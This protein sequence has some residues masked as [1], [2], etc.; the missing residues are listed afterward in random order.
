MAAQASAIALWTGVAVLAPALREELD[1]SLTQVG[2]VIAAPW[3][4]PIFTLLP[5]GIAADRAGE[6]IVLAAGLGLCASLTVVIAF[7][8]DFGA[9]V[10]LL[11][12]AG[13]AGA[14]TNAASGR[15]VMSWFGAEERGFALGIRQASTPVGIM[16]ASLALPALDRAGGLEAAFLFLA[17]FAL[18]AAVA[19]LL[20]LRDLPAETGTEEAPRVLRDRRLWLLGASAGLYLVPQVAITGF[21]VLFLHDERELS[22]Q[23][24]AAVLAVI[25][26][27][28]IPLRI[29]I[30][31][32]SDVAGDRIE[33]LRL[34]GLGGA[35]TLA[36]TAAVLDAPTWIVVVGFVVAGAVLMMWNGLSFTAA[37]ELAGRARS[38]AA[39]GFQQTVLSVTV[40]VSPPAFA[41]LVEASSWQAAFAVAALFPLA[42]VL[43]LAPLSKRRTA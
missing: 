24:A 9:V 32:W 43:P 30:G 15:A 35:V 22:I 28:A 33:P 26:V 36:A 17:A 1:L 31:R 34:V 14:S 20:V 11:G 19:G 16:V 41:G 27:I 40:A 10:V 42:G 3:I 29:A 38:G 12:L 25:Q 5:W 23:A 2:V 6:R 4:G 21:L 37:A 13:A 18:T 39:I 7:V 8:S